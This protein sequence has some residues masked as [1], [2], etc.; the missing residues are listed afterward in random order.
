MK[1]SV[2][3]RKALDLIRNN[4]KRAEHLEKAEFIKGLILLKQGK[5]AAGNA[6]IQ[7]SGI[8][9]RRWLVNYCLQEGK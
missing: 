1:K 2:K 5:S 7:R 6:A 9:G 3:I 4:M 8:Y